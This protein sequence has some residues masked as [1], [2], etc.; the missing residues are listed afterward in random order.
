MKGF[1]LTV[2]YT[3][4]RNPAF[5]FLYL[6]NE[7][8]FT[9]TFLENSLKKKTA[10]IRFN[11]AILKL[12]YSASAL[13]PYYL[14]SKYNYWW[15]WNANQKMFCFSC[16]FI[17]C[18]AWIN[19]FLLPS[20]QNLRLRYHS[21]LEFQVEDFSFFLWFIFRYIG[22]FKVNLEFS[23]SYPG[24]SFSGLDLVFKPEI[25]FIFQFQF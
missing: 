13:P 21:E 14:L 23:F 10:E 7:L 6:I 25:H 22:L 2:F 17:I 20:F 3:Y 16:V 24:F 5:L 11:C 19:C 1:F 8:E 12:N 4:H 9:L 18:D 15:L